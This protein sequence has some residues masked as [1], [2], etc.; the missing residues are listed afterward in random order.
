MHIWAH[1]VRP[2]FLYISFS[3]PQRLLFEFD[4][5]AGLFF[6]WILSVSWLTEEATRGVFDRIVKS[7]RGFLNSNSLLMRE[8]DVFREPPCP[9]GP[10]SQSLPD[11]AR[12]NMNIRRTH[13]QTL[14]PSRIST[15]TCTHAHRHPHIS[16]HTHMH[17]HTNAR[18]ITHSR[19]TFSFWN[20]VTDLKLL[21]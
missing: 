1:S 13:T 15:H 3:G 6:K 19:F 18:T 21:N 5:A 14:M 16:S 9:D 4:G 7:W 17:A 11:N 8:W 12:A 2:F 20:K 10:R